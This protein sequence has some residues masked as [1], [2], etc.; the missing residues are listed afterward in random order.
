MNIIPV[1]ASRFSSGTSVASEIAVA[2]VSEEGPI[3]DAIDSLVQQEPGMLVANDVSPGEGVADGEAPSIVI[4]AIGHTP[5]SEQLHR[6]SIYAQT[7][8]PVVLLGSDD[9]PDYAAAAWAAGIAAYIPYDEIVTHLPTVI[10]RVVAANEN[11]KEEDRRRALTVIRQML[12]SFGKLSFSAALNETAHAVQRE[13]GADV[14]EIFLADSDQDAVLNEAFAGRDREAFRIISRFKSGEGLPGI[15]YRSG[16]PLATRELQGDPRFLRRGVKERGY[17]TFVS[18][19]IKAEG[20][21]FG[22][23][24]VA[25]KNPIFAVRDANALL[26]VVAQTLGSVLYSFELTSSSRANST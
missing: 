19:P 13:S 9:D 24:N 12:S 20:R 15:T 5:L 2:V 8:V 26:D 1:S 17:T 10:R 6:L 22:T 14:C 3:H 18:N 25:S 23:I 4:A 21:I 7:G 16:Q 11:S